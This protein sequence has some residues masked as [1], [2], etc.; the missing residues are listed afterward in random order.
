MK[1]KILGKIEELR[2]RI[3]GDRGQQAKGRARRVVGDAKLAGKEIVYDAEHPRRPA[4][5]PPDRP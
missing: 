2:G 1:D 3:S 4:S 5:P